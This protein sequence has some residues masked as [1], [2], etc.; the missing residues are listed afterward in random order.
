MIVFLDYSYHQISTWGNYEKDDDWGYYSRTNSDCTFCKDKCNNDTHCG[1]VE[2]G[3]GVSYC[4]WWKRGRCVTKHEQTVQTYEHE[5]C[6]K[7]S[8]VSNLSLTMK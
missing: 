5:T 7:S 8:L 2:C 4:S 1:G 3:G 6:I